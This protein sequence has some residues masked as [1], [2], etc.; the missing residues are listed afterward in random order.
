[1]ILDFS[2]A[3]IGRRPAVGVFARDGEDLAGVENVLRI[4]RGLEAGHEGDFGRRA[5]DVQ[6]VALVQADA[7]FGGDR[8]LQ[9]GEG[10]AKFDILMTHG[11]FVLQAGV[12]NSTGTD[13]EDGVP[14]FSEELLALKRRR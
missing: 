14:G 5:R 6:E 12:A 7:V 8:T 10:G 13:L 9:P 11:I 3:V 2:G 1:M 4:Q